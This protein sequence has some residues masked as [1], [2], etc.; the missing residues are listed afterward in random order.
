MVEETSHF[1][2]YLCNGK[3]PLFYELFKWN[4]EDI[5]VLAFLIIKCFGSGKTEE[6][7]SHHYMLDFPIFWVFT[8]VDYYAFTKDK[9]ST[10]YVSSSFL[11][12]I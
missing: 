11:G 3:T 10:L 12:S 5:F 4:I 2:C 7:Y 6:N 1:I 9:Y 8:S